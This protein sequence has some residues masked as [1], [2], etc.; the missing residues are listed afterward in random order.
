M[1]YKALKSKIK[2][3]KHELEFL[4]FLLHESKNLYNTALYNVRQ[5]YFETSEYLSYYD[6]VK[7]LKN[8]QHYKTLNSSMS[9]AVLMKV[10]EAMKAFFGSIKSRDTRKVRLPR[11]LAK[12][13]FYPLI[14]RMVYKPHREYYRL[15]RSNFIKSISKSLTYGMRKKERDLYESLPF[16]NLVKELNITIPTPKCISQNNIKEITIKPKFDGKY[17]EVV[18]V[19]EVLA[20]LEEENIT[21][22]ETM[23]IDLGYVNLATCVVTN[24]NH[25]LLD[26]KKLKSYNQWYAKRMAYLQSTRTLPKSKVDEIQ[27]GNDEKEMKRIKKTVLPYT[28]QMMALEMKRSNRMTYG[29][30]K[31]ARLIINHALDNHV[32]K[33]IVGWNDG[34]KELGKTDKEN[35]WFKRIPLARLRDRIKYLSK[36]HNIECMI[37]TEEYTSKASYFDDDVLPCFNSTK[38]HTFSGKRTKRGLYTTKRGKKINADINAALN[39]LRK[40]NPNAL[41]L[42]FSGVNTP[43]RT[44]LF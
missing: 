22:T 25:L 41:K 32:K 8:N 5:H 16:S 15:P 1:R 21:K 33:I 10:D 24:G 2:L 37:I 12:D 11:Y 17:I 35:Q 26:G 20:V 29:M 6:N 3:E 23:G 13:G 7:L 39:I 4:R 38:N 28:R 30:N 44:Y 40:G 43:K 14:D 36:E 19:Y 18:Y 31:A 42:R 9:Q 27:L 34:F